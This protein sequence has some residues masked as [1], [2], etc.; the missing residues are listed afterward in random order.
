MNEKQIHPNDYLRSVCYRVAI[1]LIKDYGEE[2]AVQMLEEHVKGL[3][4]GTIKESTSTMD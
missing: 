2:K 3:L 4:D 1:G